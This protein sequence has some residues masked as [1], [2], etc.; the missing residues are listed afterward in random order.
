M[1]S[2]NAN[3]ING[4]NGAGLLDRTIN[5]MWPLWGAKRARSRFAASM[6]DSAY[7][8]GSWQD[9]SMRRWNPSSGAPDDEYDQGTQLTLT[10][11][12]RDSYRNNPVAH[13]VV[14]RLDDNVIGPGL[15][16][17]S[18][19]DHEY[20]NM[21]ESEAA[22]LEVQIERDFNAWASSKECDLSRRLNFYG[23]Q[24]LSFVSKAISGDCFV[25]TP[26]YERFGSDFGLKLQVI[27]ADRVAN[28]SSM[29]DQIDMIR[30]IRYNKLAAPV[31]YHILNAHPND[32]L[33]PGKALTGRW[34]RAFGSK[35]GRE[36]VLHLCDFSDIGRPG[37]SRGVS[38]LAPILVQLRQLRRLSEAELMAS[39]INAYFTL[40]LQS[41]NTAEYPS[42]TTQSAAEEENRQISLGPGLVQYLPEGYK[43]EFADPKRP[44]VQF[45]PFFMSIMKQIGS[46][47]GVPLEVILMH[48]TTNYWAARAAMIQLWKSVVCYRKN[49]V[50]QLCNP[51]YGLWFDEYVARGKIQ[52]DNYGNPAVRAAYIGASWDGPPKGSIDELKEINAAE[53]R[54]N[55]GVSTIQKEAQEISGLHWKDVHK[56][57]SV[58][59]KL[60]KESGLEQEKTETI[61]EAV[62]E[63]QQ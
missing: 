27:E 46:G 22:K 63:P 56:Q 11:R 2:Q 21:D 31:A 53:K 39:V 36:R 13:S 6:M 8:G 61:E 44:N 52:V 45:D 15:T 16:L 24:K 48:F 30:G 28:P 55:V 23:I 14:K 62:N 5:Y 43:P 32:S 20:L 57:R 10:A 42:S 49:L 37:Q 35:T 59:M 51:V 33:Q 12:C 3:K 38:M 19:I 26:Y 54:I 40:L 34:F 4:G 9:R 7:T 18:H 1:S 60:R 50:D 17:Q 41:E 58:E 47:T 25:N 29:P